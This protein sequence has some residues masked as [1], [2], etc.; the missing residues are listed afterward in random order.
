MLAIA[1]CATERTPRDAEPISGVHPSGFADEASENFHGKELARLGYDLNLCASCHGADFSGGKS[2]VSCNKCH[3]DKPT[4]CTTCHGVPPATGNHAPHREAN[5]ACTEC[6]VVP[7]TWDAPGH[8]GS[9]DVTFGMLAAKT[10]ASFANGTC[11][12]YCHGDAR[13][14]WDAQPVKSCDRCHGN[15]PASHAQST[16]AT[17]HKDAPHI[18]GAVQVGSACDSCHGKAGD[19]AP[20]RDL[21]GNEFTTALGV[22]AHQAHLKALSGIS[23]PIACGTCHLVP[24]SVTSP[25]HIDSLLPAE[26]ASSLGWDRA[27]GTCATAWCHG[28]ARPKWTEQGGATCGSCHGVPPSTPAHDAT[29]NV[30][31]CANCHP[32]NFAKHIDGVLDVL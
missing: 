24:A 23:A 12:V 26:V 18:D 31:T 32:A 3:A 20:P 15:P 25:G 22:G 30:T 7:A 27:A 13:P 14:R 2:G 17:C 10:P 11:T 5:V 1:A 9:A 8:I 21:A 16:C 29:M 28:N 19:P 4:S 6:H